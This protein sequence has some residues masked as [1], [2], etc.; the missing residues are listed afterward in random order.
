[1]GL[2]DLNTRFFVIGTKLHNDDLPSRL[3][4]EIKIQV[5][6]RWQ[7]YLDSPDYRKNNKNYLARK[8]P[9]L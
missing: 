2:K 6:R 5:K 9:R 3:I 1:M 7:E 8:I 4:D